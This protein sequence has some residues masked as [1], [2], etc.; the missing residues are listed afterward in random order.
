LSP[1]LLFLLTFTSMVWIVKR[2][3]K[4]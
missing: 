4:N 1:V 2:I 3:F